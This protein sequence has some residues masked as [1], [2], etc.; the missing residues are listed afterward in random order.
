MLKDTEEASLENRV[1]DEPLLIVDG[2]QTSFTTAAGS[3][4][5]VDGVSFSVRHGECVG[6]VGESGCGK[7]LTALS[8]LAW[9]LNLRR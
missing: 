5:A 6:V 2:L 9:S 7:I 8:I 4:A 3:V 1:Y